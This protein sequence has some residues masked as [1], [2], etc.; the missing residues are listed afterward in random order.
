MGM[1]RTGDG[2]DVIVGIGIDVVGIERAAGL[3]ARH[4]PRLLARCFAAGEVRRP[5]DAAHVAGLLAA[6]EAAVK[7]LGTGF[8]AGVG[9]RDAFVVRG[10]GGAPRLHLASAAARRATALGVQ[11]A[12]LSITHAAG[13]AVA[14][15]ILEA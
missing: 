15:V 1:A 3:L 9:W 12:H 7:A 13:V 5:A 2:E 4:G 10:E 8:S 14:V 6:K 11:S